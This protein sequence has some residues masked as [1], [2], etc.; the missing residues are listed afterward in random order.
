MV[1]VYTYI[2]IGYLTKLL[3]ASHQID[4]IFQAECANIFDS[5]RFGISCKYTGAPPKKKE[6][7]AMKAELDYSDSQYPHTAN[8]IDLVRCSVIFENSKD[9]LN[10]YNKFVNIINNKLNIGSAENENLNEI[11]INNDKRERC[12]R[13]IVRIKNV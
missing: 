6:R 10:A 8:V 3:I 12:I 9:M 2:Y 5:K 1:V 4:P 7:A 11:G 13:R